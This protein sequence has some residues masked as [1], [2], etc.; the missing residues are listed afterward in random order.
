MKR[1]LLAAG[2]AL[3]IVTVTMSTVTETRHMRVSDYR[4][5]NDTVPKRDTGKPKPKPDTPAI[6]CNLPF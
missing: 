3:A 4:T 1:V 6:Q 2:V 5:L